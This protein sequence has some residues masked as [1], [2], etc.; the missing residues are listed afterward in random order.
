MVDN[1]SA[2]SKLEIP[3]K[4]ARVLSI[5]ATIHKAVAVGWADKR[6]RLNVENRPPMNLHIGYAT[7]F[8]RPGVS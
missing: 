1:D 5:N 3:A 4:N 2:Q 6:V 7:K 8:L